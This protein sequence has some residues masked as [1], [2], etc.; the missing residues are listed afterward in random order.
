MGAAACEARRFPRPRRGR[1]VV[2]DRKAT[3][4]RLNTL[5]RSTL[6]RASS[7][8]L[9]PTADRRVANP[10][11]GAPSPV[12]HGLP[13][14]S[15]HDGSRDARPT[16]QRVVASRLNLPPDACRPLPPLANPPSPSRA[17]AQQKR[18][19]F[20]PSG[21]V[22]SPAFRRK[23]EALPDDSYANASVVG[24][25]SSRSSP[26]RSPDS[27]DAAAAF[28][29][30]AL[31]FASLRSTADEQ[32]AMGGL[33]EALAALAAGERV[34]FSSRGDGER[35]TKTKTK[36]NPKVDQDLTRVPIEPA[37]SRCLDAVL[38]ILFLPNAR[39]LHRAIVTAP[40]AFPP[41]ARVVAERALADALRVRIKTAR[42]ATN[43]W[44]GAARLRVLGV[45]F[46]VAS[47]QPQTAAE[48][49]VVRAVAVEA[50]ALIGEGA[51]FRARTKRAHLFFLFF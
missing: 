35:K 14:G 5:S 51:T 2:E 22:T 28:K 31:A 44:S 46:S 12:G 16:T 10:V 26:S 32:T 33:I 43:T 3:G 27:E 30:R 1:D 18:G 45:L 20:D 15:R 41:R 13:R 4:T 40:R 34:L 47:C 24:D 29:A 6:P 50:A 21:A 11:G 25:A 17:R 37:F 49:R 23:L 39:P 48:R 38:E 8:R 7:R 36:T 19:R 42:S 9:R